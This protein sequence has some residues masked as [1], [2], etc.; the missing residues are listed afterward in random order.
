MTPAEER[1]EAWWAANARINGLEDSFTRMT[2]SNC[3]S[4]YL[5]AASDADAMLEAIGKF[6]KDCDAVDETTSPH[7]CRNG[8]YCPLYPHSPYNKEK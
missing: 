4:A 1:F 6:C 3:R 5:A 2:H 8:N 7:E